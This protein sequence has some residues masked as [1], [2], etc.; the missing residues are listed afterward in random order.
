[1]TPRAAYDHRAAF[2]PSADGPSLV[3]YPCRRRDACQHCTAPV[4]QSEGAQG[5]S[6]AR[7]GVTA[8][9]YTEW[10]KNGK[11]NSQFV[12]KLSTKSGFFS[13]FRT[14]TIFRRKD[15]M[16]NCRGKA[17]FAESDS[18]AENLAPVYQDI[19]N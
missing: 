1:M 4:Q 19:G 9:V 5:S 13:P 16:E 17:E 14:S 18:W 6:L 11:K 10:E 8:A 2:S 12:E 3:A 7:P 15:F